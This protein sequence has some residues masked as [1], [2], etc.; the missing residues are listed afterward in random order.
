M[1][2]ELAI[3]GDHEAAKRLQRIGDRAVDARP[4]FREITQLLV[5]YERKRF[6]LEGPGWEPLS[7]S[8][9][10][11]KARLGQPPT[12]M[13][14]TGALERSLTSL[15]GANQRLEVERDEMVFGTTLFY[16]RFHQKTRPVVGVSG[17]QKGAISRRLKKFIVGD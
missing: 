9:V 12:P 15:G 5:G 11:R 8:T 1:R 4:V 7:P 2:L 16:A 13:V 17:S 14:A 10:A 3:T 6:D